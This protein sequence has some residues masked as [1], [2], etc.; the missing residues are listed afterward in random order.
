MQKLTRERAFLPG[1]PRCREGAYNRAVRPFLNIDAGEL[2][3]EDEALWSSAHALSIACGGHAGDERSMERVLRACGA[4]GLRCGAHPAY[5]DRAGFGR[6]TIAI[7]L[8]ALEASVRAQCESLARIARE[9]EVP[10]THA[11]LH[12]A[13]YHDG[14]R[15]PAIAEACARGVVAALGE[16][17]IL[18]PAESAIARA[19]RA[20]GCAFAREGFADR[21]LRADGALVPRGQPGAMI[22]E[23][24]RAAAQARALARTGRFDTICVHG[25]S[26]G[27]LA[28]ARAV[29]SALD[30]EPA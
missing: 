29:R 3:T 9:V 30:A 15:D 13:L 2:P 16:V 11:K 5:P 20:A 25:D 19:A 8:E 7:D 4:L 23:P 17:T 6:R 26:E 10:I 1:R 27:A 12:G 24:E 21:A 22:A 14:A 18:G 28:I